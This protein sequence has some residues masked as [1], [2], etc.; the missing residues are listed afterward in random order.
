MINE[1]F[2]KNYYMMLIFSLLFEF[3]HRERI[4][5]DQP[6]AA[7]FNKMRLQIVSPEGKPSITHFERMSY[8]GTSSVV[9][10]KMKSS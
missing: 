6:L 7:I 8:N 1:S 10:C 4:T 9:R 3:P 5:V 2:S